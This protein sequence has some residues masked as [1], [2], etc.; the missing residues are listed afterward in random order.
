MNKERKSKLM[1]SYIY[2]DEGNEEDE[3]NNSKDDWK[4]EIKKRVNGKKF[5]ES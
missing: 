4:E 5:L 3:D 2:E 1:L